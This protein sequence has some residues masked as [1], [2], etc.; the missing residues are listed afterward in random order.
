MSNLTASL[1]LLSV[2]LFVIGAVLHFIQR[3]MP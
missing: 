3:N 2:I 1:V